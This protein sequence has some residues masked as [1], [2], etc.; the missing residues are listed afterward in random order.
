MRRP[1]LNFLPLVL[2]VSLN[3]APDDIPKSLCVAKTPPKE[4]SE[5]DQGEGALTA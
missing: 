5:L 1:I 4:S 2:G 3:P